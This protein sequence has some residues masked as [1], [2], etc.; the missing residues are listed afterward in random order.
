MIFTWVPVY[1]KKQKFW[2]K[3]LES[4]RIEQTKRII[5]TVNSLHH[6]QVICESILDYYPNANLIVKVSTLAEKAALDGIKIKSFVHA[7]QETGE[8]LAKQSIF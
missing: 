7:Q 8:L 5:I 6:K 4:L 1:L 3:L 2:L